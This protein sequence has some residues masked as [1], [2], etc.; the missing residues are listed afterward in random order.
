MTALSHVPCF[1]ASFNCR[2]IISTLNWIKMQSNVVAYCNLWL[3]TSF[4]F[5][6]YWATKRLHKIKNIE[7]NNGYIVVY[8]ISINSML[9]I[10]NCLTSEDK[11]LSYIPDIK[12]SCVQLSILE[13][14]CY[15]EL[16]VTTP[17]GNDT[18]SEIKRLKSVFINILN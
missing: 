4:I 14:K 15:T 16:A 5:I 2:N 8:N 9:N 11:L 13:F 1:V 10:W 3:L 17:E 6:I 7:S 12:W 18:R